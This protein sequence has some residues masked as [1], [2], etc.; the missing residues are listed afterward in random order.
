LRDCA[1][2]RELPQAALYSQPDA[3]PLENPEEVGSCERP[4]DPSQG[5]DDLDMSGM[6]DTRRQPRPEGVP[7][8]P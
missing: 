2:S 3:P 1:E 8:L 7:D 4:V 5:F 6:E